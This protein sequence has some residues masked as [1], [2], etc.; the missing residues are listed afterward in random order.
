MKNLNVT[1]EVVERF[2]EAAET[3]IVAKFKLSKELTG[4]IQGHRLMIEADVREQNPCAVEKLET[5]ID[6]VE[7]YQSNIDYLVDVLS[8]EDGVYKITIPDTEKGLDAQIEYIEGTFREFLEEYESY[9]HL[10]R[11]LIAQHMVSKLFTEKIEKSPEWR[12]RLD[13][14]YS[15]INQAALAWSICRAKIGSALNLLNGVL[16][17]A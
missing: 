9:I 12:R 10:V 7:F 8:N 2:T 17:S 15:E 3:I 6:Y 16:I 4:F 14:L 1:K 13:G 11:A 5:T